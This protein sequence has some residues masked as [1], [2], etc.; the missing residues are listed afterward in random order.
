MTTLSQ[1]LNKLGLQA[2]KNQTLRYCRSEMGKEAISDLLGI[3]GQ[4]HTV[5]VWTNRP[6]W[7]FPC[8]AHP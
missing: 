7:F 2:I 3:I 8:R 1:T 5:Y 6:A 4:A